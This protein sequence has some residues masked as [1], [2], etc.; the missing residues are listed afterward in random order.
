M[1]IKKSNK[2]NKRK[3][4]FILAILFSPERGGRLQG[5]QVPDRHHPPNHTAQKAVSKWE[6]SW[7]ATKLPIP[8]RFCTLSSLSPSDC[9]GH[10]LG[11]RRGHRPVHRI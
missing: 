1:D 11:H 9:L 5:E 6:T 10:L 3:L 2:I 4:V 7:E 8:A